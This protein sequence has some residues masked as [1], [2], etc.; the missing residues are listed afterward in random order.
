VGDV[1]EG[2]VRKAENQV[3]GTAQLVDA[4]AGA[5]LWAE[6]YDRPLRDIF[7]LQDEIVRRIV[8]TLNLQLTLW[9][10]GYRVR[11]RTDNLEAY[12]DYLRGFEYFWSLTKE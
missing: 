9:E 8:T 6:N 1:L 7:A 3:R 10:R 11:K 2:T 5:A 12:D 4:I